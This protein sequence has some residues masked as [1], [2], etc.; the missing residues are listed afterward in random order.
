MIKR[1]ISVFLLGLVGAC[2]TSPDIQSRNARVT[3]NHVVLIKLDDP[4]DAGELMDDCDR[5]LPTIEVVRGYWC[6]QHGDFGR[7]TVDGDY[8][9]ALYVGFDSADEYA[10]YVDHENH[11]EL[12]EMWKPKFEWIRVHD[13]VNRDH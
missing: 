4:R 7:S 1:L 6:G 10:T 5:L 12:V 8:D 9:V 11:V 2:S 13:V 3:I